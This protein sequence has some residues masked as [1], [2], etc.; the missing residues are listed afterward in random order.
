LL[1]FLDLD[2][3]FLRLVVSVVFRGLDSVFVW[4]LD[5]LV[6]LRN[7]FSVGFGF[8]ILDFGL[9]SQG[10]VV[11]QD[12]SVFLGMDRMVIGCVKKEAD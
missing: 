4:I 3:W 2:A 12:S 8:W 5:F 9:V 7:D 6:S 10:L 11:F 1:V